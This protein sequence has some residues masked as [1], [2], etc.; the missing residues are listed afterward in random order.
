MPTLSQNPEPGL[1]LNEICRRIG[2][3][4]DDARYVLAKGVL[5][6]SVVESAPGRGNHRVFDDHQAFKL[7]VIL[8][9]RA[10]GVSTTVARN[11]ADWSRAVQGMSA[12]LGWDPEFA[13]FAGMLHSDKEWYLDVG[14]VRFAR[15]VTN[16][17]PSL[18]GYEVTP[19]VD[20]TTRR[21]HLS[22]RP[23]VIFRIDIVRIAQLLQGEA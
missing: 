11:I 2:V 22:A 20:M 9:L 8:M 6:D 17:N 13:P 3:D 18:D 7:A 10:G 4:Y 21:K 15:V 1:K 19:W 16:A 5:P 12:N 14:D 23:A